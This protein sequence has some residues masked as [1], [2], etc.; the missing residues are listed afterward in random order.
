MLVNI[1]D[2]AESFGT[3]IADFSKE[4]KQLMLA[5][6]LEYHVLENSARDRVIL[7]VLRK[8]DT[9][10]QVIGAEERK[11]V[12][13][14]GWAENLTS[15]NQSHDI[16]DLTPKFIRSRQPVRF[17]G[18][19]VMPEVDNFELVYLKIFRMWLFNKYFKDCNPI[20]EFGC[21]TGFNLVAISEM[22]PDKILRGSDF[23]SSSIELVNQ[24]GKTYNLN[25][26]GFL[27]D[28][29]TPDNSIKLEKGSG[30]F[31]SGAVEQLAG[32][33]ETFLQ[34]LLVQAPKIC[35]HIEPTIELYDGDNL[36]DDLAMRFLKKRGY[37]KGFLPRLIELEK[38]GKVDIIKVKRLYFGSLYQ[39][40]YM[41]IIWQVK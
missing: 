32:K 1:E 38:Q 29:I 33:F 41:C 24:I 31:T 5:H 37:T 9:D 28:M 13:E 19:Y 16:K 10:I 15:F 12:W 8:I 39:E 35:I 36:I 21:G 40:G 30:I 4:C 20:Y 6:P 17:K 14:N 27:F 26:T 2:Y 11:E 22:F 34:Y 23:V 25:I 18:N 3:T 7:D